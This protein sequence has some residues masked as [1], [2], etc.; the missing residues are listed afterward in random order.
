MVLAPSWR[1]VFVHSK[2]ETLIE[3]ASSRKIGFDFRMATQTSEAIS[4]P[5]TDT[6]WR[7][8]KSSIVVCS[9]ASNVRCTHTAITTQ[10]PY[11]V[12]T[13]TWNRYMPPSDQHMPIAC[14]SETC[15]PH[16]D[17]VTCDL[18]AVL[19]SWTRQSSKE[20]WFVRPDLFCNFVPT[21]TSSPPL[22]NQRPLP[23][24][25]P[26]L[27]LGNDPEFKA[28]RDSR[29][30]YHDLTLTQ[31]FWVIACC[32]NGRTVVPKWQYTMLDLRL[33]GPT[34]GYTTGSYPVTRCSRD[35]C[36]G[37]RKDTG[38]STKCTP[39]YVAMTYCALRRLTRCYNKYLIHEEILPVISPIIAQDDGFE[40]MDR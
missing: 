39:V 16:M 27:Y 28:L 24:L 25:W 40:F 38:R 9:I 4:R 36:A 26:K 33:T 35:E 32:R 10:L 19:Q 12:K 18:G 20:P 2:V 1:L 21:S 22:E 5:C 15:C 6:Y 29:D 31:T 3:T 13:P 37:E 30:Y 14:L 17:I 23:S 34:A 8:A 11:L 7:P